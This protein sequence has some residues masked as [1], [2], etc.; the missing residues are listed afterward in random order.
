MDNQWLEE[1][2]N[3]VLEHPSGIS[4]EDNPNFIQHKKYGNVHFSFFE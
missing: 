1:G 3:F 4:F 2:G